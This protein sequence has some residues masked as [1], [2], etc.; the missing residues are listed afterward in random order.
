MNQYDNLTSPI[1]I[2]LIGR[3]NVGKSSLFNRLTRSRKALVDYSPGLTRD[4]RYA[5]I[6][7]NGRPIEIIDT[8]GIVGEDA[9]DS[10]SGLIRHQ[11]LMAINQADVLILLVD[12]QEGLMPGDSE[13]LDTVRSLGK[14][15]VLAANKV[16]NPAMEALALDFFR[17][18]VDSVKPVSAIH[19]RGIREMMD[20][21]IDR[22]ASRA[23]EVQDGPGYVTTPGHT[24][25]DKI[26]LAIIGRPNVGK[27][28]LLN[29]LVGESRMVVADMPGTTRDAVDT[30]LKR[31]GGP[32]IILTDTAG[33]RRRA[34]VRE[35]IEKFSVLK[36]I[37]AIKTCDIALVVLD[38]S[39][40]ITDQDKRLIGYTQEH[41][42]GCITIFNKW[43]LVQGETGLIRLRQEE[44]RRAKRFAPHA[45]HINISALTGKG[46]K[47]IIP[48]AERIYADFSF[49][50][51]TG[52][53]N[54]LLRQAILKRSPPIHQG[55]HLKLYYT[56]QVATRPP[57]FTIFANYPDQIPEHYKR[58]LSNFFRREMGIEFT[59]VRLFF[60]ERERKNR[61]SVL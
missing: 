33:I 18:G 12:A 3:P 37:E 42:R 22:V 6:T 51:G 30:L 56:T 61:H 59:P 13:I 17:L 4:R 60:K 19:N 47:R 39:E 8:G 10:L 34:K 9:E 1:K 23:R 53:L 49:N 35:K 57:A 28:S 27:S 55:H 25:D 26:R 38:A 44:L 50:V 46:I 58:Y 20:T 48:L 31:D 45:P 36:A 16:D 2:A 7:W 32:D 40:G 11:S 15:F 14:P 54:R 5:K 43:D 24:E 52:R 21:A 29:A 41:T